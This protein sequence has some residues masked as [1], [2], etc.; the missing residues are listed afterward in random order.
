MQNT[1]GKMAPG[2][3]TPR[4]PGNQEAMIPT[5]ATYN[6]VRGVSIADIQE[7]YQ[8]L[9]LA[10]LTG[11]DTGTAPSSTIVG[12][13]VT[14]HNALAGQTIR[15]GD[16][17]FAMPPTIEEALTLI[18]SDGRGVPGRIPLVLKRYD[19]Q[20]TNLYN[21][22][23]VRGL[24]LEL[25]FVNADSLFA[26]LPNPVQ[27]KADETIA[28]RNMKQTLK[29]LIDTHK[30]FL[31]FATGTAADR[32]E[33]VA[34]AW[35]ILSGKP[36]IAGSDYLNGFLAE[37]V[38]QTHHGVNAAAVTVVVN[39]LKN[40][41]ARNAATLE[42]RPLERVVRQLQNLKLAVA[43]SYAGVAVIGGGPGKNFDIHLRCA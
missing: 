32:A 31:I 19:P 2:S 15:T 23:Y 17:M 21:A 1:L 10:E 5:V 3:N 20:S 6:G 26:V 29:D 33:H 11:A 22:D 12:G 41:V 27:Q 39:D 24:L 42:Q 38:K 4:A 25:V 16:H 9:G 34:I 7:Q 35:L 14:T 18:P 13:I 37:F 28:H 8:F 30:Q 36:P 40:K 43:D